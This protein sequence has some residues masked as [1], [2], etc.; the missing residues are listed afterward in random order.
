MRR[1]TLSPRA[2]RGNWGTA[3]HRV[4]GKLLRIANRKRFT[5][6]GSADDCCNGIG[7]RG[8]S[9]IDLDHRRLEAKRLNEWPEPLVAA[10]GHLLIPVARMA[11][12]GRYPGE[13]PRPG[14]LERAPA[15]H[16]D[17][18]ELERLDLGFQTTRSTGRSPRQPT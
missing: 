1:I 4:I 8:F 13:A 5:A 2:R 7:V 14:N 12:S 15:V 16:L 6:A 10:L 11:F 17:Q 9:G 3:G 18:G